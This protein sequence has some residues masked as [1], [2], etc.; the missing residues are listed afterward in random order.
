MKRNLGN[1]L[2]AAV[3]VAVMAGSSGC[4]TYVKFL[5]YKTSAT[6]TVVDVRTDP[7]GASLALSD[8]RSLKTP[9]QLVLESGT[10]MRL[11]ITQDGYE[12][13]EMELRSHADLWF[14]L[15]NL[16]L[17]P[18]LGYLVDLEQGATQNLRPHDVDVV[19][20]PLNPGTAPTTRAPLD[21]EAGG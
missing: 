8:G 9:A 12:P 19:L 6:T 10:D 20:K 11:T 7:P 1:L 15:G 17:L 2:G 18:P 3:A 14:Y 21:P 16:L 5:C 13:V 4:A